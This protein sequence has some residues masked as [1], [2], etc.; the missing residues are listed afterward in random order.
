MHELSFVQQILWQAEEAANAN[1]IKRIDEIKVVLGELLYIMPE[2][3]DF[4]FKVLNRGTAAEEARLLVEYKK[5]LAQ[6]GACGKQYFWL[7]YG[8]N[9]PKCKSQETRIIQGMEMIIEYLE[10]E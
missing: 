8:N 6:C 4:S 10:G 1:G 7:E 5:A 9:C 2:A 3:L